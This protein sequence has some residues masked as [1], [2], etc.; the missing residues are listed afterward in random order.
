MK[1]VLICDD[2]A[3]ICSLFVRFFETAGYETDMALG[4]VEAAE[5]CAQH[6]PDVVVTDLLM[7]EGDGLTLIHHL[8]EKYPAVSIIAMTGAPDA[9]LLQEAER[10]GAHSQLRKP[11]DMRRLLTAVQSVL[12]PATAET[13]SAEPEPLAV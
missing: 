13:L 10:L 1:R 6:L 12:R 4:G 3:L 7:P 11:F 2:D 9:Y 8:R 5:R